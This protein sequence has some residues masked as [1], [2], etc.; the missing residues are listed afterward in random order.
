M[1]W[2]LP[3]RGKCRGRVRPSHLENQPPE[4]YSNNLTRLLS[5]T[6]ESVG[7][8][9]FSRRDLIGHGAFAVVFR[10]RHKEVNFYIYIFLFLPISVC[11]RCTYTIFPF[12]CTFIET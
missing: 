11:S 6:M 4:L 8:F 5:T 9:E 3:A 7:K 1:K 12:I 10:G 2:D